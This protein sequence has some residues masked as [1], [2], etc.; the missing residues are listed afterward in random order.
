MFQAGLLYRVGWLL[1]FLDG[2]PLTEQEFLKN[3]TL[4]QGAPSSLLLNLAYRGGW[5][6]KDLDH[7]LKISEN[8]RVLVTTS[9]SCERL[10]KQIYALVSLLKP[11]WTR[12]AVRGRQAVGTYSPPDVA[13]CLK[14]AH[15]LDGN[16]PD[17]VTW[18]D[19]IIALAHID[20]NI[21]KLKTGRIGERLSV[22]FEANR[23][24]VMPQ[25]VAL[26]SNDAGY[27]ILSK[28]N[29]GCEEQLIIEVK[30][31]SASWRAA[32][33]FLSFNEWQILCVAQ[34]ACMHLWSVKNDVPLYAVVEVATL[35]SH[36]PA[37]QGIG[38]WHTVKIP[39]RALNAAPL[40]YKGAQ[41]P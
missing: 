19:E 11:D 27:D 38:K 2:H 36:I 15:L 18:W 29:R 28:I 16:D 31:S 10:R 35:T 3:F 30:T 1:E 40:Q 7:L 24:G 21:E 9:D 12:L 37:N 22:D 8:G 23:T 20:R 41:Q 26:D 6:T 25:W 13:Q 5:I 33:L 4:W 14:E 32:E 34:H 17:V 39:F